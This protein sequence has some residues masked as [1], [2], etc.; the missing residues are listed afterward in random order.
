MD[1]RA[2]AFCV[3]AWAGIKDVGQPVRFVPMSYAKEPPFDSVAPGEQLWIVD[4]SLQKLGEWERLLAI[5]QD[6][7][8]IDHHK[9]A[10]ERAHGTPAAVLP[11]L[12]EEG[13]D[14]GCVLT[15]QYIHW[16]SDRVRPLDDMTLP[17]VSE[18]RKNIPVP[19]A[20]ALVSD[21]DTWT[22]AKGEQTAYFHAGLSL[23]DTDPMA[24]VWRDL[25]MDSPSHMAAS[26]VRV[27]S[28]GRL[29][30]SSYSRRG[31]MICA[32]ARTILKAARDIY[33]NELECWKA[34]KIRR[35]KLHAVAAEIGTWVSNEGS[36][37]QECRKA[38]AI[39]QAERLVL[40]KNLIVAFDRASAIQNHTQDSQQTE[41]AVCTL[42]GGE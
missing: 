16:Y 33:D 39:L 38:I 10:I 15:F 21:R 8:W 37:N 13:K 32:E 34:D 11:G 9:T 12:R 36:I 2:A 42:E 35:D 22:W 29:A 41:D 19:E 17:C 6:V 23:Y 3:S 30:M 28:E 27:A 18:R 5:T 7:T 24:R 31:S 40:V 25:C 20:L 26:T 4:F 14:A 1:G